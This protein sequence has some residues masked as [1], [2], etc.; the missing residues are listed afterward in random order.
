MT[1]DT[2]EVDMTDKELRRLR[3]PEL[4]DLL[5]REVQEVD[6]L[7]VSLELQDVEMHR[8][9]DNIEHL[10]EK[11]NDKDAQIERLKEKLNDKD[12]QLEHLKR[13]LDEKDVKMKRLTT[14]LDE[15]DA[16]IAELRDEIDEE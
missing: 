9:K 7:R 2:H 4:I 11:L 6:E 12:A 13:R 8:H 16:E 15:K 1:R 5:L 14:K 3:R 10:K